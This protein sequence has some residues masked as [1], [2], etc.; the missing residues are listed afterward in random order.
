V[1]MTIYALADPDS[2]EGRSIGQTTK[3]SWK[4]DHDEASLYDDA[5]VPCRAAPAPPLHDGRTHRPLPQAPT[6]DVTVVLAP[7]RAP[8]RDFSRCL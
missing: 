4:R 3:N 2:G 7:T 5:Y 1:L 6:L 8:D